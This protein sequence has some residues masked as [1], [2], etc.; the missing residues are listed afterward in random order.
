MREEAKAFHEL[1]TPGPGLTPALGQQPW[2]LQDVLAHRPME[3]EA[4]IGQ[5]CAF[6]DEV[7]VPCPAL[8][9][10]LPLLHGLAAHGALKL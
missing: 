2:M 5:T 8:R 6:A 9:T 3:I 4:I 10:L 1:K 7:G